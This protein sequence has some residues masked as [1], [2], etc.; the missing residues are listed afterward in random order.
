[1]ANNEIISVEK[2][3]QLLDWSYDKAIN[4]VPGTSSAI[5]LAEDYLK[6]TGTLEEKID[7]LIR[8]QNIKCSTSGFITGLGG[9]ITM[10]VA[11]PAD[12]TCTIYIEL[13][14]IAAI[15]Y[16]C[17]KDIH[18][19]QVKTLALA[20]LLGDKGLNLVRDCGIQIGK[21]MTMQL[22]KKIP[23]EVIIQINKTVGFRLITKMGTKGSIN[24]VKAVPFMGGIVGGGLNLLAS[25][26]IG[27]S[28]KKMFYSG[29]NK[30]DT[31]TIDV[32]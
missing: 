14:M 25:N 9:G 16:M 24:L 15:A 32:N 30:D 27:K 26:A 1:M 7:K 17:D 8:N 12:M 22:I 10:G 6:E 31:V 13:R 23:G 29:E 5:E 19:D 28:A 11:I 3:N 20:C 2:M 21:K 4:G 18:S